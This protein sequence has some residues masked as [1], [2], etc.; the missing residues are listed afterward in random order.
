MFRS[1]GKEEVPKSGVG[2]TPVIPVLGRH[3]EEDK[4]FR[5]ILDV[6]VTVPLL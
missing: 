1:Q 2:A 3:M 4:K 5:V 6:L